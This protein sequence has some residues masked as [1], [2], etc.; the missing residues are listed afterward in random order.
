MSIHINNNHDIKMTAIPRGMR[1]RIIRNFMHFMNE[2][3]INDG[4]VD[5][6]SE[7]YSFHID[8]IIDNKF[9]DDVINKITIKEDDKIKYLKGY[10]EDIKCLKEL[11]K[12]NTDIYDVYY[13]EKDLICLYGGLMLAH[14]I[15]SNMNDPYYDDVHLYYNLLKDIMKYKDDIIHKKIT[16]EELYNLIKKY[17]SDEYGYVNKIYNIIIHLDESELYDDQDYIKKYIEQCVIAN[18][19]TLE[20]IKNGN[21]YPMINEI[22][23]E[24]DESDHVLPGLRSETIFYSNYKIGLAN[25]S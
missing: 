5:L 11:M 19:F 4:D 13:K 25:V 21:N 16:K 9:I 15:Y 12:K 22:I 14:I 1:E 6:T 17:H 18:C 24:I 10:V 7:N 8:K 2:I 20:N 23:C 3:K